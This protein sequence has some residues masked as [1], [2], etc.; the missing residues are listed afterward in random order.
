MGAIQD[1]I[2]KERLGIGKGTSKVQGDESRAARRRETKGKGRAVESEEDE[3]APQSTV[4]SS[5]APAPSAVPVST[6]PSVLHP[7]TYHH[8]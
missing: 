5:P 8:P 3:P 7:V 6:T 2:T 4:A 1:R